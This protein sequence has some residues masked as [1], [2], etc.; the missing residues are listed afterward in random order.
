MKA[1]NKAVIKAFRYPCA[2]QSLCAL[3]PLSSY[4]EIPFIS[5]NFYLKPDENGTENVEGFE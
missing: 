4:L 1:A 5:G 3:W 2:F